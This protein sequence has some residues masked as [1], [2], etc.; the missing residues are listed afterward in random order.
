MSASV[1]P[2][3]SGKYV[4]FQEYV[5]FQLRKARQQIR[6]TDLLTAGT[7]T[8]VLVI[9]YL[10]LFIVADQWLVPGGLPKVVRWVG[11]VSWL[12]LLGG[13]IAWR[14]AAPMLRSVTGLFAAKEVER[15]E[16][17]LRSNLLNWVDLQ[18]AG[19]TV[20]PS[21]LRA[22]ERQAAVQLSKMDVSQA[23]DHRPLLRS[24]YALLA[25][26]VLF[27]VYAIATPKKIGPSLARVLP[28]SD[29]LPPTRTEIRAVNPG[30]IEVT[31]GSTQEVT[32][33]LAGVIPPDVQLYFSTDDR[34]YVDEPV[35]MQPE[36]AAG[37]RFRAVLVGES[38]QGLRQGL[39]Y[40]VEAGDAVSA[41]FHV[42]VDQPPSA[43]V[44]EIR[45]DPPSYTGLPA[46]T[47]ARGDISGWEGSTVTLSAT[48]NI[49]VTSA[50]IEFVQE[51]NG[52]PTG[53][54]VKV[55]IRDGLKLTVTWQL[56]MR[57]DGTFPN[58][59]QIQCETADRRKD[60]SPVQHQYSI[61]RD[62]PPT[63]AL[64]AP[65]R[66]LEI[67]ANSV[68]PLLAQATD[69][70]EVGPVTL[71]IQQSGKTIAR[72]TL[73]PGRQ[74]SLRIQHD[75]A[76]KPLAL[77]PG[78][79]IT[80]WLAAQDN[81]QPRR[82]IK[83]TSPLKIRI[84]A[85]TEDRQVQEQLAEEK[86]RQQEQLAQL[87]QTNIDREMAAEREQGGEP[88]AEGVREKSEPPLESEAQ[89]GEQPPKDES[90]PDNQAGSEGVASGNDGDK[91]QNSKA[92]GQKNGGN[93]A[94]DKGQ[95]TDEEQPSLSP[96][97][98]DDQQVLERLLQ[99]QRESGG[100]AKP[101]TRGGK[102]P[103]AEQ[104]RPEQD[105]AP[106]SP[107][108]DKPNGPKS[109]EKKPGN[110]GDNP[111]KLGG[112]GTD[113]KGQDPGTGKS[114][115]S[116]DGL[117][118]SGDK[119]GDKPADDPAADKS[120]QKPGANAQPQTG[121]KSGTKGEPEKMVPQDGSPA[122]KPE[123]GDKP[124]PAAGEKPEPGVKPDAAG[125]P[126]PMPAE[127]ESKGSEPKPGEPKTGEPKP[128]QNG[129]PSGRPE[130]GAK[131]SPMSKDDPGMPDKGSTEKPSDGSK[132]KSEA[133]GGQKPDDA[134]KS[135]DST[136]GSKGGQAD[137]PK[138]EGQKPA[139][140]QSG[141]DGAKPQGGDKPSQG[142]SP[143]GL[144]RQSPM[145]G[146]GDPSQ[147]APNAPVDDTKTGGQGGKPVA[148]DPSKTPPPRKG[149][150]PEGM[151]T[152]PKPDAEKSPSKKSEPRDGSPN[153]EDTPPKGE[154]RKGGQRSDQPQ[155]GEKGGSAQAEDGSSGSRQ[156]GPGESTG[157]PGEQESGMSPDSKK[158]EGK[159]QPGGTPQEGANGEKAGSEKSG[160]EKS[161]GEK[162]GGEKS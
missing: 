111:P 75:L 40:R 86:A 119:P 132:P 49:P 103:N 43:Q 70:F 93:K 135:A 113:P 15:S 128:D 147:A 74:K 129:N 126:Q 2:Q 68:I 67:P 73:S 116:P 127:A 17:E 45:I 64:L 57:E 52:K 145:K 97:G 107:P 77:K 30:D 48:V 27:C 13:W 136:S 95:S 146:A 143:A 102:Q 29:V 96:D 9:G 85:P 50:K 39:S 161:G 44:D 82:N 38:G 62:Q 134:Q 158:G 61:R 156:R 109:P 69:D 118:P 31:A 76:L 78:D 87:D 28:L 60:P 160:S 115:K 153:S 130:D 138:S 25:V 12:A 155:A 144:N 46:E 55:T 125:T 36:G 148:G 106:D 54:E 3:A 154:G 32:V 98:D 72:E 89:P 8:A 20:D 140:E 133:P 22:I 1:D 150:S 18:Q 112:Q 4:D 37:T 41:T 110:K 7:V 101:G 90:P 122:T 92:N 59:Y 33:D 56:A 152:E 137:S 11:L 5:D 6:S 19:R 35:A 104:P 121:D 58:Y 34:K 149:D 151:P 65:E 100:G 141:G 24:A 114:A 81:R 66:D 83:Q 16:P 159:P 10:L 63:I 157:N 80:Y 88:L 117:P 42:K 94:A 14:M 162:S 51:S 105:P 79:E 124:Q 84:L 47:L 142:D 91:G 108:N 120:A 21:V 53:E 131:P 26:V 123:P 71:E 139:G 23:I 99:K